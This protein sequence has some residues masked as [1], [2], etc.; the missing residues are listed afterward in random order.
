MRKILFKF[1][2]FL[3][4]LFLKHSLTHKNPFEQANTDRFELDNVNMK[5]IDKI[6]YKKYSYDLL[7][8]FNVNLRILTILNDAKNKFSKRRF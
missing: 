3:E 6:R 5:D 7:N 1:D 8:H 2:W 4:R